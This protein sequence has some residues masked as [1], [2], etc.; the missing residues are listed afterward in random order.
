MT[1]ITEMSCVNNHFKLQYT[2]HEML[3]YTQTYLDL[4]CCTNQ[5]PLTMQYFLPNFFCKTL[6][7]GPKDMEIPPLPKLTSRFLHHR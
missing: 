5:Q 3:T 1:A 2:A 7:M 6:L 4:V